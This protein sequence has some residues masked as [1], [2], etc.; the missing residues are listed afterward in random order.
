MNKQ[1]LISRDN[2]EAI[3]K[4]YLKKGVDFAF[5]K[6]FGKS[7]EF[8]KEGLD[9]LTC[10]C[11]SWRKRFEESDKSILEDLVIET[12]ERL[13]YYF[14][15]AYLL[16]FE[17]NKKNLYLGLDAIEKYL[18]ER[19]DEYGLYVKGEILLRLE[20]PSDAV[21]SFSEALEIG[22]ANSR[23]L[24]RIGGTNEQHLETYGLEQLYQSFDINPSSACCVRVLKKYMKEREIEFPI[25]SSNDNPLIK[26]LCDS[27][28]EW[29]FDRLY[30]KYL[31]K[32]FLDNDLPFPQEETLP[33][34]IELINFIRSNSELF[35]LEE[36]YNEEFDH[37]DYN[38]S[39]DYY[40]EPDYE[41]DT[42]DALTDG[43]YGDYDDWR[44]A[45]GDIDSLRDG[46]GY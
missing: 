40:D 39:Y 33:V 34:I 18:N 42:F 6:S 24:Y 7:Y 31:S 32:E 41:R 17:E 8:F 5:E 29:N 35:V 22:G 9:I 28:D 16:C 36:E 38:D 10:D 14:V 20:Q 26:S 1:E 43:Q 25:D 4:Y 19:N 12:N 44:E 15:K 13:E 2:K 23:L 45:G 21:N 46:L 37:Y 11:G 30:E 27:E 3:G